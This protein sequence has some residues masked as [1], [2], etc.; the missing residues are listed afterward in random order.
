M[1]G[2]QSEPDNPV[3]LQEMP[4]TGTPLAGCNTAEASGNDGLSD[5]ERVAC[6]SERHRPVLVRTV[7]GGHVHRLHGR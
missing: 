4:I 2:A 5:T 6:R 3:I 7:Q 1:T